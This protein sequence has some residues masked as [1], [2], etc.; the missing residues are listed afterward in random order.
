MESE[1]SLLKSTVWKVA[2]SPILSEFATVWQEMGLAE[3]HRKKRREAIQDHLT[4][5]L[6]DIADEEIVLKDKMCESVGANEKELESLCQTLSL[7]VNLV[8]N[9]HGT[10]TV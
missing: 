10:G 1:L 6:R 5:L 4:N 8:S 9:N 2:E 7:P 3:E